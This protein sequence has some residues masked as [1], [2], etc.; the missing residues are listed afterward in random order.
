MAITGRLCQNDASERTLA[1]GTPVRVSK[2][3]LLVASSDSNDGSSL[4][5]E[6]QYVA[7]A[8]LVLET[9]HRTIEV[10]PVR[11]ERGIGLHESQTEVP[12]RRVARD[13]ARKQKLTW[14]AVLALVTGGLTVW[15]VVGVGTLASRLA[16]RNAQTVV[17]AQVPPDATGDQVVAVAVG[18]LTTQSPAETSTASP[19]PIGAGGLAAPP[20]VASTARSSLVEAAPNPARTVSATPS[21]TRPSEPPSRTVPAP[22]V[23][24]PPKATATPEETRAPEREVWVKP[25]GRKVWLE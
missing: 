11:L 24:T 21:R 8:P 20:K 25:S 10:A 18:A 1:S 4:D 16:S 14:I 22:V 2:S 9:D 7:P 19:D 12:H 6:R 5:G 17:N 15:I 23:A 3:C 13:A